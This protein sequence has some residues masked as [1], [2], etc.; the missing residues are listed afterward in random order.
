[1]IKATFNPNDTL[2]VMFKD[3]TISEFKCLLRALTTLKTEESDILVAETI[4][5]LKKGA[6]VIGTGFEDPDNE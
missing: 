1:M 3:L 2:T 6:S 5:A 4:E